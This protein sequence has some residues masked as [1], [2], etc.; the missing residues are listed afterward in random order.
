MSSQGPERRRIEV[1][2]IVQG[3]GFRPFVYLA[4]RSR[5][6]AGFVLN[7]PAGVT[8][9]VEGPPARIDDFLLE[10]AG[11]PP[12]GAVVDRCAAAPIPA[13]GER[14]FRIVESLTEGARSALISPDLATC[15][16]C[17]RE[18]LDPADRRHGY[19]FTNCTRC[20]PRFTIMEEV[21]YDRERTSMRRFRMCPDCARE[22]RDPADRRFHAEPVACPACGPRLDLVQPGS[23]PAPPAPAGAGASDPLARAVGLL[24]AGGIVAVKGI[25]GFQLAC[26]ARSEAA[27][28]LLRRRKRRPAKPF[29]V[30][31]GD[32]DAARA[33]AEVE[34][35]AAASL[36]SPAN[37]IVLLPAKREGGLA[38]G[39]APDTDA[40]GL[41]LPTSPLH[42]LLLRGFQGPIVM[43]SGNVTD[44]PIARTNDEARARLGAI[45][46]AFL[47][48][49]R[50]VVARY[51]D[52]VV[53]ILD[54][55]ETVLRRARGYAPRPLEMP[56]PVPRPILA[57]GGHLKAAFCLAA[58]GRA[59]LSQHIGDLDGA[60]AIEG[61]EAALA[62]YRSL[63]DIEP[64]VVAHDLHPDYASTRLAARLFPPE[65]RVAVQHHHAHIAACLAEHGKRGPAIGVAFDGAGY[66]P[67]GTV[68]GGEI[69][70]AD[71]GGYRRAASLATVPMPG[72]EAAAREPWRM[73]A[74]HLR[75]AF[76]AGFAALPIE[77]CRRLDPA[78]W[79]PLARAVE[80][81]VNAPLTSS[82]GRLFDAVASLAG[83]R[84]VN[85]HEGHAAMMLEAA[86]RSSEVPAIEIA[87]GRAP[88]AYPLPLEEGDPMLLRVAALIRGV[89]ED[90]RAGAPAALIA[91]RFHGSLA[92]GAM[93]A[94]LALRER[95]GIGLAVLSGGSFQNKVL[96][97]ALAALLRERGFDVLTHRRA[98]PNDGGVAYGQA[99]VAAEMLRKR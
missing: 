71:L 17:L 77:F 87:A 43:T 24:R 61:F 29:A 60:P 48:H 12:P 16:D 76:G 70:I 65:R 45:A 19:P 30:M 52:S 96:L 59:F 3:V 80:R 86:A 23:G 9:E 75:S 69:L 53:R 82:A 18:V 74:A 33:L 98:P 10:V 34:P 92:R 72:G 2:G 20:G 67:D 22:Y 21:P 27:V 73:A 11:S 63:F 13:R 40:V 6:L 99:A 39:V 54:G 25:G 91:A 15:A 85:L 7:G 4:A 1:G 37:P 42:H 28:G 47:E 26:D 89:V 64:E 84:D 44:E 68:W 14:E 81:G 5:G 90:L 38:A 55:G 51:D 56:D 79:R 94:C 66:G 83:L 78:R 62:R 41:L 49:D 95:T 8:I 31:A 35:I 57:V 32:L 50:E 93:E 36:S 58:G 88:G 97:E 46:D